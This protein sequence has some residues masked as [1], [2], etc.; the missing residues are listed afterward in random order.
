MPFAITWVFSFTYFKYK[1]NQT[2]ITPLG[3]LPCL[4]DSKTIQ[5]YFGTLNEI[6][7]LERNYIIIPFRPKALH[8]AMTF[9]TFCSSFFDMGCSNILF[10]LL[11]N[12]EGM[13]CNS[14]LKF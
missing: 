5:W 4:M 2:F 10:M 11:V 6:A 13:V 1:D 9:V 3:R 14:L 8:L 7:H 12:L